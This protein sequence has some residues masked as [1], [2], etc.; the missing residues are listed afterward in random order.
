MTMKALNFHVLLVSL[1]KHEILLYF[2]LLLR[3]RFATA[4]SGDGTVVLVSMDGMRWQFID[5]GYAN[6][7]NLNYLALNGVKAKYI[8]TVVPSKTW[9]NHHSFLTGLYPESHGIV[10]NNFWDPVYQEKFVLDYDC[11]NY[12]PKFYNASEP[13]W[14][15]CRRV[16]VEVECTFGQGLQATMKNQRFTKNPFATSTVTMWIPRNC[17]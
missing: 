2:A 6:T 1:V 15:T 16:V 14:L 7:P 12:D 17:R 4:S 11:S 3:M 9:P 13:I 10:S 5:S 8:K